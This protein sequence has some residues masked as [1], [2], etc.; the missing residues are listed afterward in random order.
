MK[1]LTGYIFVLKGEDKKNKV[2][3]KH[4]IYFS[5]LTDRFSC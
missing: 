1:F 5:F 3:S 2:T 4:F